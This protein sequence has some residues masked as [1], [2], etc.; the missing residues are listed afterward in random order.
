MTKDAIK[1]RLGRLL[2]WLGAHKW[3]KPYP[4]AGDKSWWGGAGHH[5]SHCARPGCK[6]VRRWHPGMYD[7]P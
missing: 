1:A 4:H 2:C 7:G 3:V 5:R 6:W